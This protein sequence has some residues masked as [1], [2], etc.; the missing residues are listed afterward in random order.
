MTYT[1]QEVQSPLHM[2]PYQY[3]H[4]LVIQQMVI[5]LEITLHVTKHRQVRRKR[6]VFYVHIFD[7]SSQ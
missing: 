2:Q 4:V 1:T 6:L 5:T 3:E 7:S